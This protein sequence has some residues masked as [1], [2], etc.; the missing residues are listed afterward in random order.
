MQKKNS[1]EASITIPRIP[2]TSG[3]LWIRPSMPRMDP[4][5]KRAS[6]ISSLVCFLNIEVIFM[7]CKSV[8]GPVLKYF[9]GSPAN[10]RVRLSK[11]FA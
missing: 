10:F 5:R 1:P 2:T 11:D 4:A 3:T 7:S 6:A 8:G 9:N